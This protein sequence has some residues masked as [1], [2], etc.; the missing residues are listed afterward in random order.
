MAIG[1]ALLR[2]SQTVL[3]AIQL[4]CAIV[5]CG[6]FAYFIAVLASRDQTSANYIR[7]VAGM[8]GAAIIYT[9]FAV[10]L[11]LCFA[12]VAFLGYIAIVLDICFAGCFAA[13]AYYSRGGARSCSGIVNTPIGV[14]SSNSNSLG[15]ACRLQTA[16]F[17]VS[18]VAI[19]LFLV[20][21][22]LQF[23]LIRHHKKEKRY[24]PSPSNNYTSGAGKLPFWKR[25]RR[26]KH[27]TRD[28]ELATT[29]GGMGRPSGETG[30]TDTTMVGGAPDPKYSQPVYGQS[31][32]GQQVPA[33]T[34]HGHNNNAST[35][36]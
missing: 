14:G 24:G 9:A 7:A 27:N 34:Y 31:G 1:G 18:I 13:I 3:R 19:F 2:I 20:T 29:S 6:I 11:T 10:L 5:A 28:A 33:N 15:R 32:Y 21:A 26:N 35:N 30:Y 8:S 12:G 16:V 17:A 23:L 22:V 36:Y 4:C 25:G